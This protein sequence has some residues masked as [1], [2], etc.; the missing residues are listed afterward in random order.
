[1]KIGIFGTGRMGKAIYH[2]VKKLGDHTVY[3]WDSHVPFDSDHHTLYDIESIT[4]IHQDFDLIISS[5]PYHLNFYLAK[6]CIEQRIPYCDLGG[7]YVGAKKINDFADKKCSV[8]F[9]DLGLAP[10]LVNIMA[11]EALRNMPEVPHTVKMRCGGLPV[12]KDSTDP[13]NYRLNWSGEGLYNEY[14]EDCEVLCDGKMITVRSLEQMETVNVPG[15]GGLEACT[16][17]GGASHTLERMRDKGVQYCTYKTLRYAGHFDLIKYF[18]LEKEFDKDQLAS[19]FKIGHGSDLVIVDI[20]A[21]ADNL[22]YR[23]NKVIHANE[24]YSAMQIA[25]AGSLASAIFATDFKKRC[26]PLEYADIEMDLFNANMK[27]L[28]IF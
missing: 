10:G 25:T 13:F 4:T 24:G 9:T 5:L 27:K 19:L 20:E 28:R 12:F 1:M 14:V 16:T 2:M 3:T 8:V 22:T 18:L 23:K 26:C 6:L 21:T 17:S 11:E 15:F 7:S